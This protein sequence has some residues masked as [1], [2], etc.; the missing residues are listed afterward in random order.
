V[1]AA[2]REIAQL[3]S[4]GAHTPRTDES[5]CSLRVLIGVIF[6]GTLLLLGL[7]TVFCL[8]LD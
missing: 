2:K 1:P 7:M 6:S 8:L 5:D 4:V 3:S